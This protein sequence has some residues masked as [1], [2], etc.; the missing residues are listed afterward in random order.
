MAEAEGLV[1]VQLERI[2]QRNQVT[3]ST[4]VMRFVYVSS[5]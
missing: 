2:D 3:Q 1:G 5:I 4:F